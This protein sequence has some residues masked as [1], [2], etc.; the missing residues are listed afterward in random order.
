[1]ED[2]A[3]WVIFRLFVRYVG[4]SGESCRR[5]PPPPAAVQAGS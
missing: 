3:G 4:G 1:M 5:H 2:T